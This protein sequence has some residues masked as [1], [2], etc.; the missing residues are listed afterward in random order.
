MK[1]INFIICL[2]ISAILVSCGDDNSDERLLLTNA[3][4]Q[5]TYQI[6]AFSQ[7][8]NETATSSTGANVNLSTTTNVGDIYSL[9]IV[10]NENGTYT[11]SGQYTLDFITKPNGSAQV[12]GS[13]I[14]DVEDLG[15][16]TISS[17][18]NTI[19]FTPSSSLEDQFLTGTYTVVLLNSTTLSLVQEAESSNGS[20]NNSTK[21]SY[22][23]IK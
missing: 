1:K 21:T 9:D 6:G 4:L 3:N 11:A 2:C 17:L 16:F 20:L 7:I 23:F 18:D 8:I 5:G 13:S 15:N 19:T 10:I 22:S 14:V 12:S